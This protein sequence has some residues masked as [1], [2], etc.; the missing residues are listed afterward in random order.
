MPILKTSRSPP[1]TRRNPLRSI[2]ESRL[3]VSTPAQSPPEA[4][5]ALLKVNP[6]PGFE[7][8]SEIVIAE[9]DPEGV[10][11]SWQTVHLNRSA[12]NNR[13]SSR[14]PFRLSAKVA[15]IVVPVPSVLTSSTSPVSSES[16]ESSELPTCLQVESPLPSRVPASAEMIPPSSIH[17]DT[18][19]VVTSFLSSH[20]Y[21]CIL[22]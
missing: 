7:S 3:S 2:P 21:R 4:V 6:S 5:S 19:F 1:L 15:S 14:T 9:L 8:P 17:P 16:S 20:R 18:V 10:S 12:K 11:S 13:R 22:V